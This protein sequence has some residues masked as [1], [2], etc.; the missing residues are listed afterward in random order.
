MPRLRPPPLQHLWKRF[1]QQGEHEVPQVSPTP[2]R[3]LSFKRVF[4]QNRNSLQAD[5][6]SS[7]ASEENGWHRH[8]MCRS[9]N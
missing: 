3:Y 5:A 4:I 9:L 8:R 2:Q 6:L 7:S 1:P